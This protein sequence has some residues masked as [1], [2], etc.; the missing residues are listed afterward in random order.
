M[1]LYRIQ[2]PFLKPGD[3]VS[4]ISPSF[5]IDEQ[6]LQDAVVFLEKWGLKVIT[7]KNASKRYGPFAGTDAERLA[8]LQEATGDPS[9]K[10]V[11]C[12]RG[13]YGLTRIIDKA[14]FSALKRSPKWFVG[15]SDVTVLN[16]WLSE[17]E[18]IASIHAD[19]PLHYNDPGKSADNFKTLRKA[20]FGKPYSISWSGEF[21]RVADAGGEITGG[22]LSILY[23]LTGT[24]AEPSTD[25]KILF[26]EDTGEYFYHI[27]RMLTSMK[28]A[29]KLRNISALV[30]GGMS[31]SV[32]TRIPWG[33]SVEET[34]MDIVKE[35]EYPV[36]FGFP[37]GHIPDNRA[38]YIGRRAKI[39]V[40]GRKAALSF[41]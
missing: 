16:L 12:A 4:I 32:D 1:P 6:K 36:F 5:C 8:D 26:I 22:N 18:G 27:D 28:L 21:H 39:T 10:A 13:G 25:G 31:D 38:F 11:F 24:P 30:I 37:A 34:I 19:M 17:V 2:P 29:G 14:D 33:R 41:E 15:F 20:L 7:G 9:V 35:F 3:K 40:K 23:S